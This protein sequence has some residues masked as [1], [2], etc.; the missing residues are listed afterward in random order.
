MIII[1]SRAEKIKKIIVIILIVV[2]VAAVSWLAVA[3]FG[4]KMEKK[5]LSSQE[6]GQTNKVVSPAEDELKQG[7]E[8]CLKFLNGLDKMSTEAVKSKEKEIV[9]ADI[10]KASPY[11]LCLSIKNNDNHYCDALNANADALKNCQDGFVQYAKTFFPAL[12]ANRCD[13]EFINECNS[14]GEKNCESSCRGLVMK[15][16]AECDNILNNPAL[17]NACLSI[18][19]DDVNVCNSTDENERKICQETFYFLKAVRENNVSYL[20][21]IEDVGY[22]SVLKLYFDP[23]TQCEKIMAGFGDYA[24]NQRFPVINQ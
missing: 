11:Y 5:R 21:K 14:V 2:I 7:R 19:K 24:C 9:E 10:G 4:K 1:D 23:N 8:V 16:L 18:N 6:P 13:P 17:K 12:K 22:R 15:E 20:D 3:Y